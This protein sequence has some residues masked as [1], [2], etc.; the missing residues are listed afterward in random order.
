MKRRK[1]FFICCLVA[2]S[3]SIFSVG[4]LVSQQLTEVYYEGTSHDVEQLV[5]NR[6]IFPEVKAVKILLEKVF[7]VA[8][9]TVL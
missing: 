1:P 4:F 8:T 9:Y 5:D 6:T 3:L 7:G 2:I